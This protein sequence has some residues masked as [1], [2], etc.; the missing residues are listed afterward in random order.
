V[1]PALGEKDRETLESGVVCDSRLVITNSV[2]PLRAPEFAKDEQNNLFVTCTAP[3]SSRSLVPGIGTGSTNDAG[4]Y[5][6]KAD[7]VETIHR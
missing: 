2:T 7:Y 5:P 1:P 6:E 3:S 4:A